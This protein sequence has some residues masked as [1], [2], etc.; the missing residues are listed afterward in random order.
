MEGEG[1]FWHKMR[2]MKITHLIT[3][4][5]CGLM[6]IGAGCSKQE[7]A[8]Q[9][10]PPAPAT[11]STTEQ[12]GADVKKAAT[13]AT[14]KA[15]ETAQK[16]VAETKEAA[17]KVT[18]QLS[19]TGSVDAAQASTE[20]PGLIARAK[21]YIADK[22]YEDALGS[23]KQLSSTRLTPEQQKI[24]D[25]L[26]AQAQKLMASDAVKSAGGLLQGK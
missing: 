7:P 17:G 18:Q 20:P 26:K 6:L 8:A 10:P 12:M 4:T 5:V 9:A 13:Q 16:V 14:E 15:K 24:V 3:A 22:K 11:K 2:N 21:A 25:D 1:V 19:S 23:L